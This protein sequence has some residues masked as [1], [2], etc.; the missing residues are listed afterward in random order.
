MLRATPGHRQYL[1][2]VFDNP[3][4]FY[5][6]IRRSNAVTTLTWPPTS[7]KTLLLLQAV[8]PNELYSAATQPSFVSLT[9]LPAFLQKR[10]TTMLGRTLS[11]KQACVGSKPAG[12]NMAPVALR[13]PKVS[14][15]AVVRTYERVGARSAVF[16]LTCRDWGVPCCQPKHFTN[17]GPSGHAAASNSL[18][19][20]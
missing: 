9:P 6:G 3:G 17:K 5:T 16:G 14:A 18:K 13:A 8:A 4:P 2:H 1:A 12:P 11:N 19:H 7:N 20:P 10:K 15:F